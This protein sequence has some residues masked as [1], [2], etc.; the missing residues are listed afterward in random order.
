MIEKNNDYPVILVPGMFGYGEKNYLSYVCPYFGTIGGNG[1]YLV[2]TAGLDC[3]TAEFRILSG[4]YER[5]CELY[6]QITGTTVDYG[7]AYAA[8][9]NTARFGRKYTTPFVPD[10][11]KENENGKI[12][13]VTLIAHGFGV[14]VARYLVFLLANGCAAEREMGYS[15]ISPLFVGGQNKAVHCVVSLAG[16]NDGTTLFQAIDYYAEGVLEK[17]VDVAY[18]IDAFFDKRKGAASRKLKGKDYLEQKMGNIFYE[19]GLDGMAEINAGISVV[20]DVYYLCYT[21]EVT[22]D[23]ARYLPKPKFGKY[24]NPF[25][26]KSYQRQLNNEFELTLPITRGFSVAPTAILLG[27]FKNYLPDAPIATERLHANDGF[28][29]TDNSLA[30]ST[31]PVAAFSS[32]NTAYPGKWYQMPIERNTHFEYIGF[33]VKRS[34]YKEFFLDVVST[35]ASLFDED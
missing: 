33:P 4:V 5:A 12:N 9:H 29:N 24:E 23:Y 26:S 18:K 34:E 1:P 25:T 19:A 21:G 16:I 7:A 11:G 28:V 30:P 27:R 3:H 6:A 22:Q 8:A 2:N 15:D 14:T 32:I 31:E 17:V 20:D 35:A 10:W 13:K